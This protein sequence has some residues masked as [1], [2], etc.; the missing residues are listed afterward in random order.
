MHTDIH[1]ACWNGDVALVT[2]FID[3]DVRLVNAPDTTEYGGNMRPL[4]YAAYQVYMYIC[5]KLHYLYD[6]FGVTTVMLLL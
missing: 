4:H 2:Q 5:I 3:V 6:V 1:T